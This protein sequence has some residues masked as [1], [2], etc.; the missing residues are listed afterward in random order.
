[1]TSLLTTA[2]RR[3]LLLG[4]LAVAGCSSATH[5][6][7]GTT[8]PA[9]GTLEEA[10]DE[11]ADVEED[12]AGDMVE[13]ESAGERTEMSDFHELSAKPKPEPD[14]DKDKSTG[15]AVMMDE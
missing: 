5:E 2:L 4:I 6:T 12:F 14:E 7:G 15:D 11:D 9:G 3:W 8:L 10:G 1:M 13:D